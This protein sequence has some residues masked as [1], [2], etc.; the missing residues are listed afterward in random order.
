MRAAIAGGTRSFKDAAE[1]IA[2]VTGRG[3]FR[4]TKTFSIAYEDA[5]LLTEATVETMFRKLMNT[6]DRSEETFEKAEDLLEDELRPE[7]PLRHRL[8]VELE[9]LRKLVVKS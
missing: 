3:R 8:S 2:I 1:S 5:T 4:M 6:P 7:S 9:E